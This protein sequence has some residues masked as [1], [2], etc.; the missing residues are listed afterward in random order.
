[1]VTLRISNKHGSVT[2]LKKDPTKN[3]SPWHSLKLN[4][5]IFLKSAFNFIRQFFYKSEFKLISKRQFE[6]SEVKR[7]LNILHVIP[8]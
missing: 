6:T 5:T 4:T 8:R 3:L 1:M 2:A 7:T